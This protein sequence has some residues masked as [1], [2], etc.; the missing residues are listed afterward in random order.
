MCRAVLERTRAALFVS[1][2]VTQT[3]VQ[4]VFAR[5]SVGGESPAWQAFLAHLD[6]LLCQ[7]LK[8]VVWTAIHTL[9]QRAERYEQVCE[10]YRYM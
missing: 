6:T 3:H 10:P 4:T 9:I 7:A 8:N 5:L 1:E 2:G